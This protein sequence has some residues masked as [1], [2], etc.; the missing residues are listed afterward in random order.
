MLL[1]S[2]SNKSVAFP[3]PKEIKSTQAVVI[4]K[5]L[6][7]TA[8]STLLPIPSLSPSVTPFLPP[9][10]NSLVIAYTI[11]DEIWVWKNG[12]AKYL[13]STSF[14]PHVIRNFGRIALS[15]DGKKLAFIDNEYEVWVI[16]TDGS[17]EKLL[18]AKEVFN[19]LPNRETIVAGKTIIL[20]HRLQWLPKSHTLLVNTLGWVS[21]SMY[22]PLNN[23][24]FVREKSGD[25]EV[26]LLEEDGQY[27]YPSPDGKQIVFLEPNEIGLMNADGSGQR[28]KLTFP[29]I[30]LGISNYY[31]KIIWG[32][33]NQSFVVFIPPP[34]SYEVHSD[35]AKLWK[36]N[37][38]ALPELLA[39]IP[40]TED[41]Y[42]FPLST[43]SPD[44]SH[45][46]YVIDH[47]ENETNN[48]LHLVSINSGYDTIIFNGKVKH[49]SWS[50]SSNHYLIV[51]SEE[52]NNALVGDVEGNV[53]SIY[54]ENTTVIEA[55]WIIENY[56]FLVTKDSL[57]VVDVSSNR[58]I[59]IT[60]IKKWSLVDTYDFSK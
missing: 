13:T 22:I 9:S 56:I 2:C 49:V 57:Q 35:L 37:I 59:H 24:Y 3:T 6:Q 23:L 16:D 58:N 36:I 30:N 45:Y 20:P 10:I 17:S 28:S 46:I 19:E 60:D 11:D 55:E 44:F 18:L 27:F 50:P 1:S 42:W 15:Y 31:P 51:T 43:I 48:E 5:T 8:T 34:M 54:V 29:S 12:G 32:Q 52:K 40:W 4:T 14:D 47:P 26:Y 33:D 39:E 7:P 25:V 21:T 41:Q 38:Y 53:A